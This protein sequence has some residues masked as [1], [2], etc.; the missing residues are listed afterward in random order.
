MYLNNLLKGGVLL[1]EGG[2]GCVFHPALNNKGEDMNTEKLVSKLQRN[3]TSALNE[4]EISN[5]V[6]NIDGYINHFAPIIKTSGVKI[7]KIQKDNL[8]N[9]SLI[10]NERVTKLI[11]MKMDYVNGIAFINYLVLNK[12][13]SNFMNNFISSYTHLLKG[14]ML[15]EENNIVHLD[16]KGDNILFNYDSELP[17]I[18]DFG[19]SIDTTKLEIKMDILKKYF[20]IYAPDYYVWPLEVHYLCY[21]L[22]ENHFPSDNELKKI[23]KAVAKN[24]IALNNNFSPAF[25]KK[26]ETLC[27]ETLL[28]YETYKNLEKRIE[29][30]L[31]Y[32]HTWDNY[33]LSVFYLN[34]F[35][36]F[37]HE[38]GYAKNDFLVFF[39]ELLLK[40]IHPDPNKRFTLIHTLQLFTEYLY[41]KNI[42]NIMSFSN[43]TRLYFNNRDIISKNM[44]KDKKSLRKTTKKLINERD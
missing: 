26:Y 12:D 11:N 3:D 14:L 5:K 2:Y 36:Y 13:D 34:F 23:A 40:N 43:I 24:N 22:K 6:K 9:C 31:K 10:T 30:I 41:N 20:Y 33:A 15:L 29:Y 18:I 37:K 39:S 7:S 16:I 25:I 32:K 17:I 42:N 35:K 1:E 19:L 4:I 27:Y 28:K 38:D 8:K 21:L 44:N